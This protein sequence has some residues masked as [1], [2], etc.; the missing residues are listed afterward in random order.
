MVH[1]RDSGVRLRAELRLGTTGESPVD[2]C[3]SQV[4]APF[5]QSQDTNQ[6]VF[7]SKLLLSILP[8]FVFVHF[9]ANL[10]LQW[11]MHL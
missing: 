3:D 2:S 5:S 6:S 9:N 4:P 10:K 1:P 11:K 8:L 7:S